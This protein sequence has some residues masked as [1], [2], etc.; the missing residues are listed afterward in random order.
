MAN[1]RSKWSEVWDIPG[2]LVEHI[3]GTFDFIGAFL[4]FFK[5]SVFKLYFFYS[6]DSF[7]TKSSMHVGVPYGS[8][9]KGTRP[10]KFL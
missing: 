8:P 10:N 9:H 4:R 1:C 2:D 6:Y 7:S 3:L 5:K